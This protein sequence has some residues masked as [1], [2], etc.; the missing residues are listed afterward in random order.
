M[1]FDENITQPLSNDDLTHL[2]ARD[3]GALH[4][5][6]SFQLSI[7]KID[8]INF[9]FLKNLYAKDAIHIVE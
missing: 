5:L 1:C 6:Y 3:L 9:S 4:L 7:H 2:F 8:K